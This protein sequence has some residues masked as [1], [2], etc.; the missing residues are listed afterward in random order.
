MAREKPNQISV[1]NET[2]EKLRRGLP[3]NRRGKIRPG[4]LTAKADKLINA[5]L[6]KE[7]RKAKIASMAKGN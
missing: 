5:A 2:W 6:D 4:A 1:R 3:T 7:E